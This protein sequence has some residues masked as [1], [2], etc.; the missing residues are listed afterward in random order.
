MSSRLARAASVKCLQAYPHDNSPDERKGK[1]MYRTI[2]ILC[3]CFVAHFALGQQ[4]APKKKESPLQKAYPKTMKKIIEFDYPH[5]RDADGELDE[6]TK[7]SA[8]GVARGMNQAEKNLGLGKKKEAENDLGFAS[9]LAEAM[10]AT[11]K[12]EEKLQ[13]LDPTRKSP[14]KFYRIRW[15]G[16][17]W[18]VTTI[19]PAK[20]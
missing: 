19:T 7:G 1:T 2:S 16:T 20:K 12:S 13:E 8:D 3:V 9:L 17:H 4:E 10:R 14:T 11:A 15:D 6:G 5:L 18:S